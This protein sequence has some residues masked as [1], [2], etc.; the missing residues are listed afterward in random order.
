MDNILIR[1]TAQ[2]YENYGTA[3]DPYWKPKGGYE[4]NLRSDC[5]YFY[6]RTEECEIAIQRM[7]NAKSNDHHK[8]VYISHELTYSAISSLDSREFEDTFNQVC[9]EYDDAMVD[10]LAGNN[11]S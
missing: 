3:E 6:Y 7:L 9:A 5:D 11:P 10:S 1:I 2:Y 8:W 4:F